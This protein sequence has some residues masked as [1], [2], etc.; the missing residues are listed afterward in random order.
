MCKAHSLLYHS[1]KRKSQ[2]PIPTPGPPKE[3]QTSTILIAFPGAERSQNLNATPLA[4]G[5]KPPTANPSST[6]PQPR[7]PQESWIWR[8]LPAF[9]GAERTLNLHA[10]P[11]AQSGPISSRYK[12]MTAWYNKFELIYTDLNPGPLI[13]NPA[14]P[15][16]SRVLDLENTFSISRRRLFSR[17]PLQ[18]AKKIRRV[19]SPPKT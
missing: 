16:T 9:P 17:P 10:T 15:E 13:H 18:N 4:H 6:I 2:S 3:S 11:L 1:K 14:T 12:L 5:Q 7:Q 19:L 8:T